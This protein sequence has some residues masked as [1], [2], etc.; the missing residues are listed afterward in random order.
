MLFLKSV[1]LATRSMSLT[2]ALTGAVIFTTPIW[3]DF[4]LWGLGVVKGSV[5]G[6][7]NFKD[8]TILVFN[9]PTF[10]DHSVLIQATNSLLR[11]LVK[12]QYVSC[13][14]L[15]ILSD[16]LGCI[17]V[18]KGNTVA[19]IREAILKCRKPIAISPSA[20]DSFEDQTKLPPFKTGAFVA[21]EHILPVAISY[22]PY[23]RWPSNQ[24]ISTAI[25]NRLTG[26]F[27]QY[28][29]S[30]LPKV[31]KNADESPEDFASRVKQQ[32]EEALNSH[33][34]S[35]ESL[36]ESPKPLLVLSSLAFGI[37][38]YFVYLAG[39]YVHAIGI[40]IVFLTSIWYHSTGSIEAKFIDTFSNFA[41]GI[42]FSIHGLIQG[43]YIMFI[44]ALIAVLGFI[45]FQSKSTIGHLIGVHIPVILGFLTLI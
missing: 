16:K 7:E 43:N 24:P 2:M 17:S 40:F 10:F 44:Y 33:R 26:G 14:P 5:S 22:F 19:R 21:S 13:Y 4:F 18:D 25:Y 36:D 37:C 32:I 39:N 9:H 11:F 29:V 27:I 35:E 30:I 8:N 34:P 42:I 45:T 1:L 38:A 15:K 41:L 12:E 28:H 20:G 3:N 23:E 31:T 6:I